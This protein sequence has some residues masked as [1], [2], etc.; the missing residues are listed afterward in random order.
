LTPGQVFMGCT[1]PQHAEL[2]LRVE[3]LERRLAALEGGRAPALEALPREVVERHEAAVGLTWLNRLGAAAVVAAL[4]FGAAWAHEH[5]YLTAP[6]RTALLVAVAAAMLWFGVALR[7]GDAGRRMFGY[8]VALI[9][10]FGLYLAPYTASSMDALVSAATGATLVVAL[11]VAFAAAAVRLREEA[12]AQ[13]GAAGGLSA[14]LVAFGAEPD[15]WLVYGYLTALSATMLWLERRGGWRRVTPVL[16]VGCSGYYLMMAGDPDASVTAVWLGLGLFAALHLEALGRRQ[17][18]SLLHHAGFGATMTALASV[19]ATGGGPGAA[20]RVAALGALLVLA[21]CALRRRGAE[22]GGTALLVGAGAALVA[23]AAIT[24]A[25]PAAA[26]LVCAALG[27]VLIELTWRYGTGETWELLGWSGLVTS[28]GAVALAAGATG[29]Q[30]PT[31][32]LIV[33][34]ALALVALG[35]RRRDGRTR[36]MGVLLLG[37]AAAKLSCL[38]IWRLDAGPRVAALLVLGAALLAASYLYGRQLS[39]AR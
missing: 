4:G 9:G 29:A 24:G 23:L 7:R 33:G 18:L 12:L 31:T 35:I 20:A 15:F 27:A 21:G 17:A 37:A 13:L 34:H 2:S 11:T 38:D 19:S 3:R 10:A 22:A 28:A 8:G 26:A 16:A 14:P 36:L 25:S 32:L 39:R 6:L 1:D 30:L 5:G